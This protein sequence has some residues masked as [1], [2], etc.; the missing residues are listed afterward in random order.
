MKIAVLGA[1][2]P[3]TIALLIHLARAEVELPLELALVARDTAALRAV[4]EGAIAIEP[5][6]RA[7]AMEAVAFDRL[8]DAVAGAAIAIVQ[9]RA[10]GLAGRAFDETFP[11]A[12][13]ICGDEGLGPGG[14]AAAWRSWPV[15]Q[16]IGAALARAAPAALAIVLTSPTSLLVGALARRFPTMRFVGVCELPLTT[17]LDVCAASGVAVEDVELEYVGTNHSGWF[18]RMACGA[19]DLIGEH[20]ARAA[21]GAFP[22][23]ADIAAC[24][25]ALPTKYLELHYHPQ[26]CLQ[27][28]LSAPGARVRVVA[29]WRQRLLDAASRSDGPSTAAI[30]SERPAP[31]YEHAVSPL[32][33]DI[34]GRAGGS[35]RLYFLSVAHGDRSEVTELAYRVH[36]G[37]LVARPA[38]HV[39]AQVLAT[40]KQQVAYETAAAESVV[41]RA[42]ELV[43]AALARHPWVRDP[44]HI[45]A[46][47][48]AITDQESMGST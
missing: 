36:A 13:G 45:D 32:V 9:I 24:G 4:R 20:A 8:D 47:A 35:D 17:L 10:G 38:H 44:V 5:R 40:W 14:F 43:R 1:S 7:L 30:L 6:C 25:H 11:H 37:E 34:L 19:R 29:D 27:R 21:L 16:R 2:S 28:Q 18:T 12:F 3:S 22:S 23:A 31:W 15:L 39:P 48:R 26:R 46:L 42:P 41:A 33:L